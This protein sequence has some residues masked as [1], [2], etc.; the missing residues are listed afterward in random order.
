MR[1]WRRSCFDCMGGIADAAGNNLY[2]PIPLVNDVP[3]APVATGPIR[4]WDDERMTQRR[5]KLLAVI[6]NLFPMAY[7]PVETPFNGD[8]PAIHGGG[9]YNRMTCWQP[10]D[11]GTSCTSTNT[12][13]G[14]I[15][16][17]N[18][19]K[20]A[21][22]AYLFQQAWVPWGSDPKRPMPSVGDIYLLYR[23]KIT[24]PIQKA[25][26]KPH[27]RHCGFVVHVPTQPGEPWVTADGGQTEQSGMRQAAFLNRRPWELRKAGEGV[28][29]H[30]LWEQT[31]TAHGFPVPLADVEYPYLG[32]GAEA[33]GDLADAN[34]ML[35]WIDMDAAAIVFKK[36]AFDPPQA[37]LR[38]LFKYTE[39]D[40]RELGRK[41]DALL[42]D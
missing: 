13:V 41:I 25:T 12:F 40:Y 35:G 31:V 36:E 24:S 37:K 34:R 7:W 1:D 32:G 29:P 8:A 18:A 42:A 20:W 22:A 14:G 38:T 17:D 16:T 6:G 39:A 19:T 15:L 28:E 2:E 4:T 9:H 30:D 33:T 3:A 23:D 27:L 21:F 5:K 10:S 11:G 26:D